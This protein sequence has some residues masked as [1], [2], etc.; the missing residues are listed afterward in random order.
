[1]LTKNP[2]FIRNLWIELSPHRLIAT[3]LILLL[4]F[5]L[6]GTWTGAHGIQSAA[7]VLFLIV[8][9][10]GGSMQA[11]GAVLSEVKGGTWM[12]QRLTA[13]QPWAMTWGKLFGSTA[14]SWYTGAGCLA[15]FV[16]AGLLHERDAVSR[17]AVLGGDI[18]LSVLYLVGVA[19]LFQVM[20]LVSSLINASG[21]SL[22]SRRNSRAGILV[23]LLI[24]M[25]FLNLFR[26]AT[27]M[28]SLQW[29]EMSFIP[30]YFWLASL[31]VFVAWGLTG[32][33]MLMRKQLQVANG[34]GVWL[35][36]VLFLIFY[37]DGFIHA[38]SFFAS[39]P[40][41]AGVWR[42]GFAVSASVSASYLMVFWERTSVVDIQRL[43]RCLDLGRSV[44]SLQETPLWALTAG[45]AVAFGAA[46]MMYLKLQGYAPT[47]ATP[48]NLYSLTTAVLGF[49]MRDLGLVLYFQFSKKSERASLT[50]LVYFGILYFL[51]PAFVRAI[52]LPSL[53]PWFLP[54][55]R[56]SVLGDSIPAFVQAALMW[57]AVARQWRGRTAIDTMPRA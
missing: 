14:F 2:E 20:G 12:L 53:L 39:S 6:F 35:A 24:A 18:T 36:F 21:F 7:T 29:W 9:V 54:T 31:Y 47:L 4:S 3:P 34:P 13:I 57:L 26:Q 17:W 49:M 41:M 28:S 48:P 30:K 38:G 37:I 46:F 23:L 8:V 11:S 15:A 44:Q 55:G 33:Y 45:L 52:D 25:P 27:T 50:A 43:R 56:G 1:M 22:Q 19:L 16:S 51:L 42:L 5:Y 40:T 10:G 32:S